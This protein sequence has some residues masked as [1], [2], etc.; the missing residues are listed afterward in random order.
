[1]RISRIEVKNFRILKNFAI[2]L[3]NN[4]SVVIGKNNTGKTSL[5]HI[6]QK[7]LNSPSNT[8]NFEDFSIPYQGI[9][10]EKIESELI[11]EESYDDLKIELKIFIEYG[12]DDSLENIN[13]LFL[14]LEPSNNE[15][16]LSFE[17]GLT[18][19]NYVKLKEDYKNHELGRSLIDFIKKHHKTYFKIKRKAVDPSEESNTIEIEDYKIQKII[20]IQS[21]SA[22]RDVSNEDGDGT[23]SEKTLSRLSY[24]YFKPFEDSRAP[25]VIDLQK[26]LIETDNNL[27]GSYEQIF[28]GII[29]DVEKFSYND[30]KL[31]IKSNFEEVNLLKENTSVVYNENDC[32]LPESYNGLG[33][34]N[35][36]SMIF[37]L[38]IIF[39]QFKKTHQE[40]E[41]AD[42]NLLFIEEPEAHTHPQMQYVFIKN[43]KEFLSENKDS[44][45]LQTILTTHSSHITSQADFLDIKY[46]LVKDC[47]AIVKNLKDL[48]NQYGTSQQSKINFK[49]LKQYLTLHRAELFFSDKI[50][51]IE[52]DT[53]RI[54]LPAIMKKLDLENA[55]TA[56]YKPL[57]SQKISIVEVGAHSKIF[58][59]FLEFL[60]VKTLI[61]TDLD[62]VKDDGDGNKVACRVSDGTE[63]SNCS[64]K[65]FLAGKNFNEIK[66]ISDQDRIISRGGT[67]IYLAYQNEENGYSPRSFEDAF[68]S[69]N[70]DFI[71]DKK[72]EISGIK[73][74]KFE[75][76]L[77]K[78][79]A[80][81]Y[82]LGGCV[83]SKTNFATDILYCSDEDLSGWQTPDYIKKG[84]LWL[85][86]G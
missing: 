34:M 32:L 78:T 9:I 14:D 48:K 76:E 2:H 50:I 80:D 12:D 45:N 25:H 79:T 31:S 19:D 23:G 71:K 74:K 82:Q 61:I 24:K 5:M 65:H 17:Y 36:F 21:I 51:F 40:S 6:M 43:I 8:F 18:Y 46:F 57:L 11:D 70:L 38:H 44:L 13:S 39:D 73:P 3:E 29:D 49:F 58:D 85:M 84:L 20:N 27:T 7:F 26:K 33:Y 62:S 60:E 16:L 47:E 28:K 42:I 66:N 63:T 41:P 30:S 10:L 54:L 37:E 86:E 75:E 56:S 1:M 15:V 53:E 67:K 69:L 77:A 22:Q 4:L 72:E 68:I 64:I 59:K 81:Y 55:G 35:L 83:S 52:G